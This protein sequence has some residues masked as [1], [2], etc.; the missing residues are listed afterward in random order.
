MPD[1]QVVQ[2]IRIPGAKTTGA[3]APRAHTPQQEK[4][5]QL[6]ALTLQ[7]ERSPSSPQLEKDCMQQQPSKTNPSPHPKKENTIVV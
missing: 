7:L 6:E 1:F 4:P 2:W 5:L 3:H